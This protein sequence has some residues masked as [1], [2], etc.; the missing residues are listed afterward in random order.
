VVL[1]ATEAR[2]QSLLRRDPKFF[3]N[4]AGKSGEVVP[5]EEVEKIR[6]DL[7]L[8]ILELEELKK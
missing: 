4:G 2:L 8:A 1:K 3:V 6:A 7:F 5:V